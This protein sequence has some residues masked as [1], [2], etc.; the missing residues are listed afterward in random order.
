M[1]NLLKQIISICMNWILNFKSI[2]LPAVIFETYMACIYA[3]GISMNI[4]TTDSPNLAHENMNLYTDSTQSI[5]DRPENLVH[6]QW[7]DQLD[8]TSGLF[9]FHDKYA[10]SPKGLWTK[11]I[12]ISLLTMPTIMKQ[13]LNETR[14]LLKTTGKLTH[15][16]KL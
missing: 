3:L 9:L 1:P 6:L 14:H 11:P 15:K 10:G 12:N 7:L 5:K 16:I 4:Q 2:N 8:R 13:K